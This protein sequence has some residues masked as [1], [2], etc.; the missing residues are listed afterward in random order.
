[1]VTGSPFLSRA[2]GLRSPFRVRVKPHLQLARVPD[3]FAVHSGYDVAAPKTEPGSEAVRFHMGDQ[4]AFP[5][6]R[7]EQARQLRGQVLH[8][9]SHHP[10]GAFPLRERRTVKP[11]ALFQHLRC[12]VDGRAGSQRHGDGVTGTR[13]DGDAPAAFLDGHDREIGAASQFRDGDPFRLSRPDLP[14]DSGS[15]RG[16]SVWRVAVLRWRGRWKRPPPGRSRWVAVG[17]RRSG[18]PRVSGS[19]DRGRPVSPP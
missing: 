4:Y 11:E 8:V 1:M 17:P 7:S 13:I 12:G 2:N 18:S 15:S 9:H 5:Q 6:C 3:G 16:Y 10:C 19:W 14:A